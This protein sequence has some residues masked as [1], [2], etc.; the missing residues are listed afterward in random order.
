M[1]V[2]WKRVLV[3]ERFGQAPEEEPVVHGEQAAEVHLGYG[4]Q[5]AFRNTGKRAFHKSY[6]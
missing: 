5:I 3:Q 2:L 6:N 4:R 1:R